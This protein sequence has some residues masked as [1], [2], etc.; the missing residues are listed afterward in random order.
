MTQYT[1]DSKK[2][3]FFHNGLVKRT[4]ESLGP[5]EDGPNGVSL[6]T[7]LFDDLSQAN[8][9]PSNGYEL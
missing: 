7:E 8:G 6:A 1:R 2:R 5:K 4:D 9:D 3:R